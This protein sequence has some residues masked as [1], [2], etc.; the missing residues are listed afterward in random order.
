MKQ[1]RLNYKEKRK[2]LLEEFT[3]QNIH[4]AVLELIGERGVEALTVNLVAQ[5]AGIAKGTVYLHFK[6]KDE[7]ICSSIDASLDPL[8]SGLM[9]ILDSDLDPIEKLKKYAFFSTDFFDH[10]RNT[11]RALLYNQHQAHVR[12]ERYMDNNYERFIEKLASVF[13]EGIESGVFR[14]MDTKIAATIFVESSISITIQYILNDA[15][16]DLKNDVNNLFD[17]IL[18]GIL[19][20]QSQT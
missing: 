8:F 7:L 11:F 18:N 20:N 5:R 16:R 2:H 19:S 3:K 13:K 6:D 9:E 14:P 1:K 4:E 15:Q 10:Y 12:K 17:I